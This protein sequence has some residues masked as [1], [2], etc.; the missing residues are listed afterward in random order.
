MHNV[1]KIFPNCLLRWDH[2]AGG[3]VGHISAWKMNTKQARQCMVAP[4]PVA[5]WSCGSSTSC[6]YTGC[7][8]CSDG[9]V[10]WAAAEHDA[11]KNVLI[12][13]APPSL[14]ISHIRPEVYPYYHANARQLATLS[15]NFCSV[16]LEASE[17]IYQRPRVWEPEIEQ[18]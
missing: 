14:I 11:Q 4:A 8:R 6:S 16:R 3:D 10:A 9:E 12:A 2:S 7:Q 18:F 13:P 15:M 17:Y 1:A 5:G